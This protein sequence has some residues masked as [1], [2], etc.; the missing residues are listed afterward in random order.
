LLDQITE[1]F[2]AQ[3]VAKIPELSSNVAALFVNAPRLV[4][5]PISY[6]IINTRPFDIAVAT[7]VDFVGLIYLLIL[8]VCYRQLA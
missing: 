5:Q 4:S 6:T 8:A 3:Y 1:D 7:A 2:N